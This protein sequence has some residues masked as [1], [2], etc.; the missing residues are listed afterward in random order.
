MI[1]VQNLQRLL[2][3][4]RKLSFL[5]IIPFLLISCGAFKKSQPTPWPSDDEIGEVK[6]ET[7]VETKD[8]PTSDG[9]K[10]LSNET[11]HKK[12]EEVNFKG[13]QYQVPIHKKEFEIAVLLP[14][15]SDASNSSIDQRRSNI[16]LEYYQGMKLAIPELEH[17]ESKFLIRYYD[18]DNDTNKLKE[19]LKNP[20]IE[21]VDLILG[22]TDNDQLRI[23][24][25]FARKR[26]I[27]LIS[28]I[29]TI[30][31]LW[32]DNPYVFNV[33]PSDKMQVQ[34]FLHYF[35]QNHTGEKLLIVRDGKYFDRSFGQTLV[36]E[37]I[38]KG[39]KYQEVKYSGKIRWNEHVSDEGTVVFHTGR[40]KTAM[41]NVVTG[42]QNRSKGV[43]LV[44][45][46]DWMDLSSVDYAQLQKLNITYISTNK[47][48]IPNDMADK[49]YSSYTSSY[50][51]T[52][53]FYTYMGYDQL[54]FACES[55]DAFGKYF[56]LFL[57]NK[58]IEY[59]NTDF[60]LIK[61]E[62]S[63][64]NLYLGIFQLKEDRLI[65]VN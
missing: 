64:H 19:L 61:S 17:L 60:R 55:L 20:K 32:S 36:E 45:P 2:S 9:D 6:N 11:K 29:T 7:E 4:N 65:K 13:D 47:A 34:E 38:A 3:G 50:N 27:P 56:P 25:F 54:M 28:P 23:A 18:T 24:A 15:H 35:N 46:E 49:L 57:E 22:P 53:S 39:V 41:S 14:F 1:S 37:C 48:Q 58:S 43:T 5:L 8:E 42:L 44:G 33:N 16:M 31:K 59:S 26:E 30:D 63:F 40:T 10:V 21:N 52:P 62:N 51:G 12:Y